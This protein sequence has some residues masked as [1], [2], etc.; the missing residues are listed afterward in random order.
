MMERIKG[1]CTAENLFII[2]GMVSVGT[3]SFALGKA[4]KGEWDIEMI[5]DAFKVLFG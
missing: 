4:S 5:L 2:K 1:W 3:I